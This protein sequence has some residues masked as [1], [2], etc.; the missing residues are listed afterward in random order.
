V[1]PESFAALTLARI[2]RPW[3]RRGEV[4][5]EI[6]TDYPDRLTRLREVWLA[7]SSGPPKRTAVS[8]CRLHNGQAVFLFSG[9]SSIDEA[10]KLRGLEV[11][12]PLS[13]R[14]QLPQ[15]RYYISELLGCEVW[16]EGAASQLGSVR[17]VQSIN[18]EAG[19]PESWVLALD[20]P[21]G[22]VLIPLAAE[23]CTRID[24]AARRIDVHLPAGL[25]KLN[26]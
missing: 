1:S 3:G 14:V 5:A 18:A 6:L 16:E 20:T 23:I 8:S 11:Q 9:V 15:D 17:E 2:L 22:E 13:E 21:R 19:A 4:A 26:P 25:L 12:V 10:E 7:G 24:I